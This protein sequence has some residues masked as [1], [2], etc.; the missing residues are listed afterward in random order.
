MN[1]EL[2][3]A[4]YE[5]TRRAAA[6][7]D[8]L[9]FVNF[10]NSKYEANWH[11]KLLIKKIERF[12]KD[13]DAKR[14]MVF[15][16]PQHGKSEI[17]SRALPAFQLG[18]DPTCR[19]AAASYS[20]DLAKAFNRSVQRIIDTQA[21]SSV[22]PKTRMPTKRTVS[23]AR[24]SFLRNTN[25]FEIVGTGGSYKAVGVGGGLSG[26]AVDL[27]LIDDPVKDYK[28]ASS[29][30]VRES[31]W[32]WYLN[33]LLARL[34]NDSKVIIIMTRWHEDD[35]AGRLLARE[36]HLWDVFS[37][38]AIKEPGGMPGD[39][40]AIGEALWPQRHSLEK[41]L[42][43]RALSERTF[44]S[45]FQQRPAPEDG[46]VLKRKWW[47]YY[48]PAEINWGMQTIHFFIDSAYTD[49]SNNDPTAIL[50][51]ARINNRMYLVGSH[52]KWLPFPELIKWIPEYVY[53]RGG[54]A[55]SAVVIE[56]KASGKSIV[57]MLRAT[58]SLNI[59]ED[60]A[61]TDS[62]ETR[63]KA[64]SPIPEAG[65]V[66]LPENAEWVEKFINQCAVFPNGTLDDRVD[67]FEMACRRLIVNQ[68]GTTDWKV[69]SA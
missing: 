3:A 28:E 57:Q 2:A 54:N 58:T 48:N 62:K 31:I 46:D 10:T 56:P 8:F 36:P 63:V 17:V 50:A 64:I 68:P 25:E 45:L 11:H 67:T 55:K 39:P 12:I 52:E 32:Q 15:M 19:I 37:L 59:I 44:A 26:R 60:V 40:R 7:G 42:A 23:D 51:A 27:A 30:V 6:D 49:N 61:P 18:L 16:P 1:R 5:K 24:G 33:V 38:A 65:R 35:L 53:L 14:L 66:Y 47:R 34:H 41:L 69:G 43:L 29:P 20:A 9:S 13:P 21:Y 4:I 22:F